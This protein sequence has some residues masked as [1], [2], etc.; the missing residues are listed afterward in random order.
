MARGMTWGMGSLG[1]TL[2]GLSVSKSS[3]DGRLLSVLSLRRVRI[4]T[5]GGTSGFSSG[6]LWE[7]WWRLVGLKLEALKDPAGPELERC[8]R[9]WGLSWF[10]VTACSHW[11]L[12]PQS[13]WCSCSPS[14]YAKLIWPFPRKLRLPG[15]PYWKDEVLGTRHWLSEVLE[16]NSTSLSSASSED[17]SPM[18]GRGGRGFVV[19]LGEQ[20][21]MCS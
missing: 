11:G 21:G 6:W 3:T 13:F 4:G 1:G 5:R 19:L 14:W 15:K 7:E 20:G 18:S 2:G 8:S 9:R 12:T 17:R 10:C 16:K